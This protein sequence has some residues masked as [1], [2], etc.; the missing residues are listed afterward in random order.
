MK[1]L[2]VLRTMID[3]FG[4]DCDPHVAQREDGWYVGEVTNKKTGDHF[5]ILMEPML[6][7]LTVQIHNVSKEVKKQN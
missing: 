3:Y 7:G 2:A 4:D 1:T 5:R 6:D